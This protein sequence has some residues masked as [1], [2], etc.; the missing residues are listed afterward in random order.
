MTKRKAK[1][2]ASAGTPASKKAG[3]ATV[4]NTPSFFYTAT[5]VAKQDCA[6]DKAAIDKNC[7]P[8]KE[9]D[10][11]KR[12]KSRN[13]LLSKIK[14]PTHGG[15][16][17]KPDAQWINDHCEFL[18][19]KPSSPEDMFKELSDIPAKMADDLGTKALETVK[20]KAQEKL[21][22]A[23]EKK[24]AKMGLKQV[25]ARLGSFL[26]GPWTGV[27][28]NI[29]MTADGANDLKNAVEEFPDL[30]NEFE[31]AK[32]QLE[33]AEKKI[34]EFTKEFDKYKDPT[35]ASGF[36]EQAMVS[37]MMHG[38]AEMNPCIRARRCSLVPYNQTENPAAKN[39]KGC[40]PGQSGHHVLPSSMFKDCPDYK[41]AQAPT[42]CVEGTTNSHGSHG[43]IHGKL[44]EKLGDL[45]YVGGKK[46]PPGAPIMKKDAI[47]AGAKSVDDAFP[48][49]KCDARCIKA[50]LSAFYDKLNCTAKN[51]SGETKKK[52]SPSIP[53]STKD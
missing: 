21:T 53:N 33:A 51:A 40:C 46:I 19:I 47:D 16:S 20:T 38:A 50:Q 29:A 15:K 9:D 3:G 2:Q 13:G 25:A 1:T 18:M 10:K 48:L 44:G 28:V 17:T 30:K 22:T 24:L 49:S 43:L 41:E 11:L 39:G 52:Q 45:M 12:Q 35:K 26:G 5:K 31:Q 32:Q 23:V 34:T 14:L 37:D 42:I 8:E 6:K 36:N 7:K 4:G 27:A